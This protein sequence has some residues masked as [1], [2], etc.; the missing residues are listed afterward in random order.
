MENPHCMSFY[1]F[2]IQWKH[3][4]KHETD[5]TPTSNWVCLWST[6]FYPG[7]RLWLST[8]SLDQQPSRTAFW[9]ALVPHTQ[10]LPS[11]PTFCCHTHRAL[12]PLFLWRVPAH[13]HHPLMQPTEPERVR[14]KHT[15]LSIMW[16]Q[17]LAKK[18]GQLRESILVTS[19]MVFRLNVSE[20]GHHA[21]CQF[22]TAHPGYC[23]SCLWSGALVHR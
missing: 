11:T 23:T 15:F 14:H 10:C 19:A 16:Q 2:L 7:K 12:S 5:L 13:P 4:E 21:P 9:R 8:F 18:Q 1:I 3:A 6:F 20:M 17:P 22:T